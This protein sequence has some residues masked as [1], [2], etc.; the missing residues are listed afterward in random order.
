MKPFPDHI[1]ALHFVGIGGI[2]MSGLA[3]IARALGLTVQG[4]DQKEGANTQRLAASGVRIM[5]GHTAEN[6]KLPNGEFPQAVVISS[7]IKQ[8]NPE[9]TEA[10]AHHIPVVGRAEF[11]ERVAHGVGRGRV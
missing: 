5:V 11:D 8:N 7:A 4:S 9:I 10:I 2:G 1:K 3:E 6:V